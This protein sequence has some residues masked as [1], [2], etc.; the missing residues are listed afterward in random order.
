MIVGDLI[1]RWATCQEVRHFFGQRAPRRRFA[2]HHNLDSAITARITPSIHAGKSTKVSHSPPSEPS[3]PSEPAEP[4]D[5]AA[6]RAT[7]SGNRASAWP[8]TVPRSFSTV[9]GTCE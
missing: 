6:Y 9:V 8:S 4:S 2:H 3:E 5:A 7:I 1:G